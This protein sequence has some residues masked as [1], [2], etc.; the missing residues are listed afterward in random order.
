MI[1]NANG[2]FL[3]YKEDAG[4]IN[5]Y[6]QNIVKIIKKIFINNPEWNINIILCDDHIFNNQNKTLH[7]NINFEHTL[8]KNGGRSVLDGTPVGNIKCD[9]NETYLVRIDNYDN[10][11]KAD[12][13]I[14]YSI[15]NI[16]NVQNCPMYDS[17]S[18]K[19]I[20]ISSSI[21]ELY[22]LKINRNIITLTTFINTNEPRRR[23]LLNK[24]NNEKIEHTNVNNC[25][26]TDALQHLLKNTKILINIHQTPHH[27]TFEELRVLPALEC[28][29]VVISEI[30]PLM[31][32]I[33][34][35]D[36]I[37]WTNYED[38]IDK[39][40]EVIENYDYFHD[41]VFST[42]NIKVLLNLKNVNY[43]VLQNTFLKLQT[44][45]I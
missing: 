21:Y 39:I 17:F 32:T 37:I 40:K 22:T 20:Y 19:H 12:I 2:S 43:N 11:I 14:D 16:H 9:I 26:N 13:I 5:D 30:S 27:H 44:I 23:E 41:I 45:S 15:P 35:K 6:Y 1:F 29:V 42:D 25:F 31:D 38:I 33:P 8:V 28:G 7:I 3:F 36:M 18:K 24:I 34:Y 10:L 4:I